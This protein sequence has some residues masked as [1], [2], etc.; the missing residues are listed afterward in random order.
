MSDTG[1]TILVISGRSEN[2]GQLRSVLR[3]CRERIGELAYCDNAQAGYQVLAREPVDWVLI[4][5]QLGAVSGMDV[6]SRIH[7]S[8]PDVPVVVVTGS[9]NAPLQDA[10]LKDEYLAAG[11][12]DVLC[13]DDLD[14]AELERCLDIQVVADRALI[15]EQSG[16]ISPEPAG[17]ML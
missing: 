9:Q 2:Y 11:A 4:D 8:W 5:H 10:D 3:K 14:Q 13:R 6:L 16:P 1:L 12:R 15:A 17:S 7:Y